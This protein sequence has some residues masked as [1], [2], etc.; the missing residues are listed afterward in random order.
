MTDEEKARAIIKMCCDSIV[1]KSHRL[2]FKNDGKIH[3][4]DRK[5]LKYIAETLV[6]ALEKG[7]FV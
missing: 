3:D 2:R 7:W 5:R 6:M 1:E 4:G